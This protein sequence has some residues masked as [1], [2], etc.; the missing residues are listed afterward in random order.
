MKEVFI[1]SENEEIFSMFAANLSYLP[2]HFSWVGD[3]DNAEKQFRSE[4]PDFVFFAVKK[5]TLLNNWLARYKSFK[6]KIPYLCFVSNIGWERRELLWMAGAAE[7]IELPKLKKEFIQIVESVLVPKNNEVEPD[8]LS[9]N[10]NIFNVID[11]IK[12]FEEGNKNGIIELKNRNRV[13]QLQFNKGNLVHAVY[14]SKDPLEAVLSMSIWNEGIFSV[15]PD[16]VRHSQLIKLNNQQIIKECQDYIVE[17][18][19]LIS[20]M[21][22]TDLVFYALPTLDYEELSPLARKNLLFFKNGKNL[23]EFFEQDEDG[24]LK[25]LK[26]LKSWFDKN[27]LVDKLV[28]KK[29]QLLLKEQQNASAMKK[30]FAKVFSK[31]EEEI[32]TE[33]EIPAE[34]MSVEK[35]LVFSS[36]K[37]SNLFQNF[38][39]IKE[40]E[41]ALGAKS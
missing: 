21:P 32:T 4:K 29:K 13:G 6:L 40:F 28:Y 39:L 37:K 9:G 5:L 27:W 18:E 22:D 25:L 11:L 17:R 7:V 19:K 38:E 16:N 33:N 36:Q 12:T 23:K 8:F 41:E 34:E 14:N 24:S 30:I 35:N 2:V 31:K 10:L 3:M 1:V 20:M 15:K 26:E